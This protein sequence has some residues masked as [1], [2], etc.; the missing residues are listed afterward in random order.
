MHLSTGLAA[1]FTCCMCPYM[2]PT[3]IFSCTGFWC[4]GKKIK[5]TKRAQQRKLY[6]YHCTCPTFKLCTPLKNDLV[7]S[8]QTCQNKPPAHIHSITVHATVVDAHITARYQS[9]VTHDGAHH[10]GTR[11]TPQQPQ[12]CLAKTTDSQSF[13]ARINLAATLNNG[14]LNLLQSF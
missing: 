5:A 8:T 4:A 7:S 3:C 10:E 12:T 11:H 6:S 2:R 9:F 14:C 1:T 13:P